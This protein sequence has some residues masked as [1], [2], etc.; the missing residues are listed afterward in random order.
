MGLKVRTGGGQNGRRGFTLVE[1]LV[2]IAIIGLLIGIGMPAL[3]KAR[4]SARRTKCLVNLRSF[5][6]GLE[7][8]FKDSKDLLPKVLPF[9]P[10]T[11]T[12]SNDGQ[13]LDVMTRYIDAN[14]PVR[15][16][17]NDPNSPYIPV[18]PYFCPSDKGPDA[19][20]ALGVSYEYYPGYLMLIRE[21]RMDP[22]PARSV[23]VYYTNYP[24]TP[25]MADAKPFHQAINSVGQNALYFGS[26]A[27]DWYV[28][29]PPP[30]PE[31]L[32]DPPT[33]P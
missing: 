22:S 21:L 29:P 15:E 11:G 25:V 7:M 10:S 3:A 23:T 26:W 5:G 13:L 1:L 8:Y 16:D 28:E 33:N 9:Y 24:K 18:D 31:W 30:P 17:P 14:A 20:R 4:E 19:G 27:V 6:T 2:V 32:T 12:P